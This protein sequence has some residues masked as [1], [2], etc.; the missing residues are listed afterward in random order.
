M[1][2]N[3]YLNGIHINKVGDSL[4]RVW[5]PPSKPEHRD[6]DGESDLGVYGNTYHNSLR[7]AI[8]FLAMTAWLEMESSGWTPNYLAPK[9]NMT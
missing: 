3:N 8:S 6:T 7:E 9:S 4:W 2:D 1:A 5:I